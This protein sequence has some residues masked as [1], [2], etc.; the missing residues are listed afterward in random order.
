MKIGLRFL[1]RRI[2][3]IGVVVMIVAVSM[4]ITQ[5]SLNVAT[6]KQI[7]L[8]AGATLGVL[9]KYHRQESAPHQPL[10]AASYAGAYA[11]PRGQL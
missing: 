4:L 8:W 7:W 5:L 6:M 11:T 2:D 3:A 10:T 1:K 9:A